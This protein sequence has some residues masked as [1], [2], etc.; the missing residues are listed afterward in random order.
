MQ[1]K[2]VYYVLSVA[3][4][5]YTEHHLDLFLFLPCTLFFLAFC[6]TAC[7]A[8]RHVKVYLLKFYFCVFHCIRKS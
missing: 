6:R 8:S 5:T 7:P 2:V 4:S 3:E 1:K